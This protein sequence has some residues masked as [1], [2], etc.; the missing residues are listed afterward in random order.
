MRL[1]CITQRFNDITL[2]NIRIGRQDFLWI[3]IEKIEE[4]F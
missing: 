4:I 1:R 2:F 3:G